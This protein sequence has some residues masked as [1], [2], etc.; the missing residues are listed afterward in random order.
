V[1]P[2]APPKEIIPPPP[3][4]QWEPPAPGPGDNELPNG[5]P[6]SKEPGA[7]GAGAG[8]GE[9]VGAEAGANPA[10]GGEKEKK[11]VP[12]KKLRELWE[13][14]HGKKWPKDPKTGRNQDVSHEKPLADGGS[15]D[16]RNIKPRPHDEHMQKHKDASDFIRWGKRR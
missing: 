10:K 16:A 12:P 13:K 2:V 11:R 5:G 1:G 3:A 15:N 6:G 7:V 9:G 14:L 4:P 8:A